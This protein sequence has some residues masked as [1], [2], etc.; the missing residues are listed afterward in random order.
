VRFDDS[1]LSILRHVTETLRK[2]GG[3]GAAAPG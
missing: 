2:Q 1:V 3:F